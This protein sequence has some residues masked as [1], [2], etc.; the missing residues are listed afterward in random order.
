MTNER[1]I[2]LYILRHATWKT[3]ACVAAVV[4]GTFVVDPVL[5]A[6]ESLADWARDTVQVACDKMAD[7]SLEEVRELGE[8]YRQER[9]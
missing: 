2:L 1:T 8:R 5:E 9:R 3:R 6:L 7:F 4:V